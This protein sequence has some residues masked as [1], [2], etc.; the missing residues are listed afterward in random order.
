MCQ[1]D[2]GDGEKATREFSEK[3]VSEGGGSVNILSAGSTK[4]NG[5]ERVRKRKCQ[6][7]RYAKSAIERRREHS[8]TIS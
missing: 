5:K 4:R 6:K 3:R 1:P 8:E 2:G 7:R